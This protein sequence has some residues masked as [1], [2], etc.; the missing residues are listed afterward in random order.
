MQTTKDKQTT[1]IRKQ[2]DQCLPGRKN[3]AAIHRQTMVVHQGVVQRCNQVK[4]GLRGDEKL[5]QKD[6]GLKW[7]N[8]LKWT[9]LPESKCL[10]KAFDPPDPMGKKRTNTLELLIIAHTRTLQGRPMDYP[11]LPI[12]FQTGHPLEGPGNGSL[13]YDFHLSPRGFFHP[14][15]SPNSRVVSYAKATAVRCL[16]LSCRSGVQDDR[17]MPRVTDRG[18]GDTDV[19]KGREVVKRTIRNPCLPS[20]FPDRRSL[21]GKFAGETK[22]VHSAGARS[23]SVGRRVGGFA[24]RRLRRKKLAVVD[25]TSNLLVCSGGNVR[26]EWPRFAY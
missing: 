12:G 1:Q 25:E 15:S 4:T 5:Q 18:G 26:T 6:A 3:M 2:P 19:W 22:D 7:L 9:L 17:D 24:W 8:P 10:C 16:D 11:T 21:E 20:F 23:P 14:A 13:F